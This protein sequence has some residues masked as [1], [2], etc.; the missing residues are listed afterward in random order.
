MIYRWNL[1]RRNN[2]TVGKP[3][4][5]LVHWKKRVDKLGMLTEAQ[6]FWTSVHEYILRII[7]QAVP[8]SISLFL[9]GDPSILKGTIPTIY[10]E[11]VQ[12]FI[13][14]GRRL[15]TRQWKV[16][17][18]PSVHDWHNLLARVAACEQ[19]SFSLLGR[20]ELYYLKWERLFLYIYSP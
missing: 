7:G 12:T 2:N 15:L 3:I 11:W 10:T 19:L 5:L 8:F 18:A 14:L 17:H 13:I 4:A 9:L 1:S 16:A 6:D 20:T